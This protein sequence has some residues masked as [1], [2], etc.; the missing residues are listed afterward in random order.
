MQELNINELRQLSVKIDQKTT[1]ATFNEKSVFLA[2]SYLNKML[3]FSEFYHVS[4]GINI[5]KLIKEV[6]DYKKSEFYH[7]LQLIKK[8]INKLV[9]SVEDLIRRRNS[10]KYV[11]FNPLVNSKT[12]SEITSKNW[13]TFEY[14]KRDKIYP[15]EFRLITRKN[16]GFVSCGMS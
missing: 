16:W 3:T 1:L 14:N 13:Q 4:I 2:K 5:R 10:P 8:Y 12:Y 9:S 11:Y 6:N 7:F 15:G